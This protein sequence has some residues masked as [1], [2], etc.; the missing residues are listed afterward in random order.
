MRSLRLPVS[1]SHQAVLGSWSHLVLQQIVFVVV[2][3]L[4]S[5][6]VQMTEVHLWRNTKGRT[7]ERRRL[8]GGKLDAYEAARPVLREQLGVPKRPLWTQDRGKDAQELK[9]K[10]PWLSAPSL[11]LSLS[12][13]RLSR[14]K[15]SSCLPCNRRSG[16]TPMRHRPRRASRLRRNPRG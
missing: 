7:F 16:R 6:T 1:D 4:L 13:L 2:W 15:A 12:L 14:R 9:G 5:R 3:Q 11:H 10:G 8:G